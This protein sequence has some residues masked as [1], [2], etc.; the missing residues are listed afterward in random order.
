MSNEKKSI[1]GS[2]SGDKALERY[3]D[4]LTARLK[5]IKA[6][7]WKKGW[8]GMNRKF[9]W[10]QNMRGGHY[11]GTNVFFL[12]LDASSNNYRTPVYLTYNQAKKNGLWINNARDYMP[13]TFYDTRYYM[14]REYR[15]TEEDNKSIEY[16]DW[17]SL[18]KS[19]KDKYDS[20]TVMR[21]FL[22]Y[23]LDQSNAETEKPELYQKYLDKFFERQTF[24]DKEGLYENPVLDRMIANQDWLCRFKEDQYTQ[25]PCYMPGKDIIV[26]PK[27]EQ[28]K[29]GNTPEELLVQGQIYYATLIHEM[30][31][32]LG[33]PDRL[34]RDTLIYYSDHENR[35]KE[36][37]TAELGSA[38]VCNM[39]GFDS[40][41]DDRHVAYFDSWLHALEN[42]PKYL[43][44]VL[45]NVKKSITPIIEKYDKISAELGLQPIL[46]ESNK[47][48][49]KETNEKNLSS[50][51]QKGKKASLDIPDNM[52]ERKTSR[53]RKRSTSLSR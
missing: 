25:Y 22:V 12:Q 36:E 42:D 43:K 46:G 39:L 16:K 38:I 14:K 20:Y 1:T 32:S 4:M 19:E 44:S 23:N 29:T 28:Y 45:S 3:V 10:P 17:N 34:N 18:P 52:V 24:T 2:K 47:V 53:S 6:S 26:M 37:L 33:T 30:V 21:A 40:K 9:G 35:A 27:K 31:H 48:S 51:E 49:V 8:I 11:N 5:E 13:V 7:D 15:Q 41:I 50:K